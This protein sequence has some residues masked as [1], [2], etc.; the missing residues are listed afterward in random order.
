MRNVWL[1]VKREY[2]SGVRTR[3]FWITTLLMPLLV[4]LLLG[5]PAHLANYR[6]GIS[7]SIV[8][9]ASDSG[10]G[11]AL[12]MEL[13]R[14]GQNSGIKYKITLSTNATEAE[15]ETLRARV[16]GSELDG[17]LWATD[18]A[19]AARNF[20]YVARAT[21][22]FLEMASLNIAV[23][24]AAISQRLAMRGVARGDLDDVMRSVRLETIR[25]EQGRESVWSSRGMLTMTFLLVTSLYGLVLMYGVILM[26]SVLEEKSSRI[27]EVLLS[28]VTARQL[29]AGKILGVGAVGMTQMALWFVMAAMAVAPMLMKWRDVAA[30]IQ[31]PPGAL[32]FFPVFFV[33]GYLLYSA[34]WATLAAVVNSEQEAYHLQTFVML[35]LLFSVIMVLFIIRQPS[36]PLAVALSM[37]PFC[38]PLLMYVRILVETPPAWQIA[39]C[40]ALLAGTT[41][42]LL[43]VCSR[44]YRIGI[45]M[46]GK[47]PTLPEVWK[48]MRYA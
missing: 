32:A 28:A 48:W 21:N 8:V 7:R 25:I 12:R 16:A 30:G 4:A 43:V 17:Y 2:L 9:V 26:R 15:R 45:L 3:G 22:D 41:W 40:L 39:L 36:T 31:L 23:F 10:F 11:E 19:L 35:P 29:M 33:L 1:I 14:Q 20:Q 13:E 5:L 42:A 47:R 38:A 27:M 46:Y 37:I 18:E 44:V 6:P 24:R 34:L